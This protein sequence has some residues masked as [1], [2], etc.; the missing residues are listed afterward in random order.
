MTNDSSLESY[1]YD[2]DAALRRERSVIACAITAFGLLGTFGVYD[3][4]IEN[5]PIRHLVLE[6]AMNFI[7]LVIGAYL[8]TRLVR[9]KHRS[10]LV[11][12]TEYIKARESA[13][14]FKLQIEK[15]REGV[16]AAITQQLKLWK[17]TPT[18]E[19]ICFFL[20]KGFSLQ[21]IAD[22]R[23]TSERTIRQQAS[24]LYKK[25]GLSG[26]S[27]LSAFFLEDLLAVDPATENGRRMSEY[28]SS[29]GHGAMRSVV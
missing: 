22:L 2:N 9:S 26:R 10:L 3:D 13:E 1:E 25:T 5:V 6:G 16:S 23:N 11:L 12:R 7:A 14:S 27:Q 8:F 17:L 15:F 21:E 29:N 18:E 20:L 4:W 19:E 28:K 24:M